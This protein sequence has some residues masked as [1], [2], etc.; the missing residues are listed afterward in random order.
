[1]FTARITAPWS[2]ATA[3]NQVLGEWTLPNGQVV[4]GLT[5]NWVPEPNDASADKQMLHFRAWVDGYDDKGASKTADIGVVVW[6]YVWP[7]FAWSIQQD[8]TYAPS[9]VKLDALATNPKL[10]SQFTNEKLTVTYT[11]P[12]NLEVQKNKGSQAQLRLANEGSYPVKLVL[13]DTRGNSTTLT[14][15]LLAIHALPFKITAKTSPSNALW[16]EPV[17]VLARADAT[18][19]HPSDHV[20]SYAFAVDGVPIDTKGSSAQFNLPT[21]GDHVMEVTL[22]SRFGAVQVADFPITVIQNKPPVCKL[23]GKSNV[24]ARVVT[25]EATCTDADGKVLGYAW[26]VNDSKVGSTAPKLTLALPGAG[27]GLSVTVQATDDSGGTGTAT[28]TMQF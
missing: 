23:I 10:M 12:D 4:P 1:M 2:P 3:V 27:E 18:G 8:T 6:Q 15:D 7:T 11:F 16:R 14:T 20:L 21:A 13:A 5:L 9:I 25:V 17:T 28:V 19:G 22:T 24:P 26:W